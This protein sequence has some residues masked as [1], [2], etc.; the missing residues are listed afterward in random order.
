[1]TRESLT[2]VVTFSPSRAHAGFL[3]GRIGEGL[4][5]TADGHGFPPGSS[6]YPTTVMLTELLLCM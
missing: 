1:M 3:N 6:R 4:T 2:G 5:A